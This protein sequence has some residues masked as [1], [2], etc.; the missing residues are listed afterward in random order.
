MTEAQWEVRID[1]VAIS[2]AGVLHRQGNDMVHIPAEIHA[3]VLGLPWEVAF[4]VGIPD[5]GELIPEIT[6]LHI[7]QREDGAPI[8]ADLIRSFR[9]G[10]ARDEAVKIASHRWVSAGGDRWML[11]FDP[12]SPR[13]MKAAT[14]RRSRRVTD[15]DVRRAAVTYQEAKRTGRR[16]CLVAVAVA[17]GVSRATAARYVNRAIDAG[18]MEEDR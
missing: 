18:M 11:D 15:E 7:R 5:D 3:R 9:L 1:P 12:V 13:R 2:G 16:D 8:G 10:R 4:T 17:C 14:Q 6:E